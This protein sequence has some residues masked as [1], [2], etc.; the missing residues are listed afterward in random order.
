M[1]TAKR[2]LSSILEA[3]PPQ[4]HRLRLIACVSDI[5][6]RKRVNATAGRDREPI[7]ALASRLITAQ[8]EERRRIAREIHDDFCQELAALTFDVGELIAET[9]PVTLRSRFRNLQNRLKN[10]SDSARHLA[11]R[12]HPSILEDLGLAASLKA[13]CDELS[14]RNGVT[15]K[16]ANRQLPDRLPLPLMS[17]FYRIAQEGVRNALKHSGAKHIGITLT[18]TKK[19]VALSIRD[20]G[21]GFDLSSAK[22]K[23]GLGL[24]S[25]EERIRLVDGKLS[26]RSAPGHGTSIVA[27][28]PLSKDAS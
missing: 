3:S 8:E 9:I 24:A 15:V 7:R 13:L 23:G 10:L 4:H 22:R 19:S 21:S 5:T 17:C 1:R 26:I 14:H 2:K 27:S 20:A 18:G 11:Y 25:M 16:F 28:A 12:L 6:E